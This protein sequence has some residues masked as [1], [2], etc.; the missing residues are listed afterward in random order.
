MRDEP[1]VLP[2]AAAVEVDLEDG[3]VRRAGKLLDPAEGRERDSGLP[4]LR[5]RERVPRRQRVVHRF[6]CNRRAGRETERLSTRSASRRRTRASCSRPSRI[7]ELD[8]ERDRRRPRRPSC[9]TR[10]RCPRPCRRWP[11]R[12][13]G[14][15]TRCPVRDRVE[16]ELQA[17][18]AVFERVAALT[19]SQGACPGRRAAT[20]PQPSLYASR[21][22]E[23]EAARLGARGS[24]R[25]CA[26]RSTSASSSTVCL[27]SAP[28]RASSGMMSLKTIPRLREVRDVPDLGSQA[29]DTQRRRGLRRSRQKSSCESS[30]A[31]S[32]SVS[33]CWMPPSRRSGLRERR[34]G[35]RP[36]GA[37]RPRGRPRSGTCAG[38]APRCRSARAS[39]MRPRCRRR[40]PGRASRC[41][42]RRGCSRP[43]SSSSRASSARIRGALAQL[44]EIELVLGLPEAAR[45]LA[46]A[47]LARPGRRGELLADHAQRQELVALEPEDRLEALD[48]VLAE[49]AV[50]A[51]RAARREQALVLEVADLGDRDV[52]ELALQR[53][54]DGADREQRASALLA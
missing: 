48:V 29:S 54:A 26:A 47:L 34:A 39:R 9:S 22:A 17:V 46:P 53:A 30:C 13:R 10:P 31:S 15:A 11:A 5:A 36:G 3:R 1:R 28:G 8:H 12:R 14:P 50:A 4:T 52:R 42:S 6:R 32:A 24:R 41:P 7:V 45:A 16:V 19:V 2:A 33:S 21:G 35:A 23:D 51:P 18:L 25:A 44:R 37:V 38:A 43:Y 49:E 40:S 27:Q 20:K